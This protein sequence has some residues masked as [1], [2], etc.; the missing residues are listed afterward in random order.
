MNTNSQESEGNSS[1]SLNASLI[2]EKCLDD[3]KEIAAHAELSKEL[4]DIL[5]DNGDWEVRHELIT[6]AIFNETIAE[7]LSDSQIL[8]IIENK[9]TS[10]LQWLSLEI[11]SFLYPG[12]YNKV[13]HTEKR[14]C[15]LETL[16][17][18]IKALVKS[19]DAKIFENLIGIVSI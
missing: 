11:Y 3:I 14:R 7:W 2:G 4:F 9:N 5:W 10:I 8:Q 18:L 16:K 17:K 6:R 1:N 15:S 13:N 12:G 19:G